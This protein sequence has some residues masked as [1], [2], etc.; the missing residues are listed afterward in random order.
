MGEFEKIRIELIELHGDGGSV[1]VFRNTF[2]IH[3]GNFGKFNR[4]LRLN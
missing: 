1:L 4:Y 3:E 2:I